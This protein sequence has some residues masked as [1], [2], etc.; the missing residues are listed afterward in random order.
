MGWYKG[1]WKF[2]FRLIAES[3]SDRWFWPFS[4]SLGEDKLLTAKVPNMSLKPDECVAVDDFMQGAN[5]F[6]VAIYANI[7]NRQI[8]GKAYVL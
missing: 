7:S 8:C 4:Y 3:A 5:L 1:F 6:D 2:D